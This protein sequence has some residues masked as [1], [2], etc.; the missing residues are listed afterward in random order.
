MTDY[1]RELEK[2]V[3][4]IYA[5]A[6]LRLERAQMDLMFEATA[7]HT[8]EDVRYRRRAIANARAQA[9]AQGVLDAYR[10]MARNLGNALRQI[11]ETFHGAHNG[12][13]QAGQDA[14]NTYTLG[15]PA[16]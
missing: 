15:G 12:V 13:R 3:G 2:A 1:R 4:A 6:D 5:E 9:R 16:K 8:L 11:T 14:R 10:T 7:P